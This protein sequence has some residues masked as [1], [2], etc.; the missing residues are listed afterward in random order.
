MVGCGMDEA[1]EEAP[2]TTQPNNAF[3]AIGVDSFCKKL[4]YTFFQVNVISI[5]CDKMNLLVSN[6]EATYLIYVTI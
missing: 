3:I 6:F 5:F 4:D 2:D 1:E